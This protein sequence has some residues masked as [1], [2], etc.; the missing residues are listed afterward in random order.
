[1]WTG[2]PQQQTWATHW[3]KSSLL[4]GY[5]AAKNT[6]D[7]LRTLSY[8]HTCFGTEQRVLTVCMAACMAVVLYTLY[9][10]TLISIL[11]PHGVSTGRCFS[12]V[13]LFLISLAVWI[14]CTFGTVPQPFTVSAAHLA[15]ALSVPSLVFLHLLQLNFLMWKGSRVLPLRNCFRYFAHTDRH[16]Q[17]FGLK[18]CQFAF[19]ERHT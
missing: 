12:A 9:F 14:A 16:V 3:T 5:Q 4:P 13:M 2:V 15:L 1:M 7:L 19:T 11:S 10:N 6:V 8:T 18:E 17:C